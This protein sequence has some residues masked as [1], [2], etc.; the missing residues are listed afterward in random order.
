[1]PFFATDLEAIGCH[2]T[3]NL[4]LVCANQPGCRAFG[5]LG[6]GPEVLTRLYL[7]PLEALRENNA[8]FGSSFEETDRGQH[9]GYAH[10]DRDAEYVEV[11]VGVDQDTFRT[12][13]DGVRT[14]GSKNCEVHIS[15]KFGRARP[16]D[17]V[18]TV[19]P[20]EGLHRIEVR[21]RR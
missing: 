3:P 11:T 19:L 15:P 1:M 8:H 13:A 14:F 9:I 12:I 7:C 5:V 10:Y 4:Q 21:A 2:P 17:T 18:D 20:V 6:A 16:H